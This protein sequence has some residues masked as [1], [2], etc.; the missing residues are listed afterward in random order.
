M[1]VK[2]AEHFTFWT[3]FRS[4]RRAL[5]QLLFQKTPSELFLMALG[6]DRRWMNLSLAVTQEMFSLILEWATC[7]G[8]LEVSWSSPCSGRV[9]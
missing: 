1:S 9:S 6:W 8:P 5:K 3:Q 4:V 7:K 2:W